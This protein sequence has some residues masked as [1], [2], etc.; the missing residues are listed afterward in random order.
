MLISA[1][2]IAAAEFDKVLV[3][4]TIEKDLSL[5]SQVQKLGLNLG[6]HEGVEKFAGAQGIAGVSK[7]IEPQR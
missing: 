3:A 6:T 5:A 7:D 1:K 4:R 2:D